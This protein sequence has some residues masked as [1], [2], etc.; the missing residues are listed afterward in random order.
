MSEASTLIP[1]DHYIL[2]LG[3]GIV[4]ELPGMCPVALA[5]G[6][7]GEISL[8]RVLGQASN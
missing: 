1:T 3:L 2:Y 7:G 8:A 4:L 6:D 5:P